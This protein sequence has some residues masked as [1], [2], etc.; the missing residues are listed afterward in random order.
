LNAR[1]FKKKKDQNSQ[2]DP[3]SLLR[4]RGKGRENIWKV[5]LKHNEVKGNLKTRKEKTQRKR[6]TYRK[7]GKAP[8]QRQENFWQPFE[9]RGWRQR[10]PTPNN[11]QKH[12]ILTAKKKRGLKKMWTEI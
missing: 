3:E 4:V 7:N 1:K 9:R 2:G 8:T 10:T 11:K 6:G 5:N 12:R